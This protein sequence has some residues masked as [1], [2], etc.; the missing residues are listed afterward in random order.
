[1]VST[2]RSRG[3]SGYDVAMSMLSHNDIHTYTPAL[4][5]AGLAQVEI[6]TFETVISRLVWTQ[7][8]A[9]TVAEIIHGELLDHLHFPFQD[10]QRLFWRTSNLEG[11][12]GPLDAMGPVPQDAPRRHRTRN[13]SKHASRWCG[14]GGVGFSRPPNQGEIFSDF[15]ELGKCHRSVPGTM[16]ALANSKTINKNILTAFFS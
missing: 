3:L 1:M 4:R 11:A 10:L 2:M 12:E 13:L 5:I 6:H 16:Q 8:R 9:T 15:S 14:G 7:S